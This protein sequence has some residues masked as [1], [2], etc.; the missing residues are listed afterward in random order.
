MFSFSRRSC[1]SCAGTLLAVFVLSQ[2]LLPLP[3]ND[4]ALFRSSAGHGG[5]LHVGL[6]PAGRGRKGAVSHVGRGLRR[7]GAP[8]RLTQSFYERFTPGL[9]RCSRRPF[10]SRNVL[11]THAVVPSGPALPSAP[12]LPHPPIARPHP[13][14]PPPASPATMPD[15]IR[16]GCVHVFRLWCMILVHIPAKNPLIGSFRLHVNMVST[17]EVSFY[18]HIKCRYRVGR[19]E[20]S[21]L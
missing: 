17:K 13:F 19:M 6:S 5:T 1:R 2:V 10:R 7:R 11:Q 16:P 9:E 20:R 21:L 12:L 3:T 4:F 14:R 8:R 15:L 18:V